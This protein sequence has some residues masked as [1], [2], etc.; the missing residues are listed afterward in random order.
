MLVEKSR[1]KRS[2]AS[3]NT[4]LFFYVYGNKKMIQKVVEKYE[5]SLK[6]AKVKSA[7]RAGR[8][9]PEIPVTRFLLI[10]IHLILLPR[11][12]EASGFLQSSDKEVIFLFSGGK[13]LLGSQLPSQQ[14]PVHWDHSQ[15]WSA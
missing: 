8:S 14:G 13:S 4:H 12:L 9:G 1:S 7:L 2:A 5:S 15:A 3:V 11:L 10:N 6:S